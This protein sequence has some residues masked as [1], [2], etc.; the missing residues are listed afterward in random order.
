MDP[1]IPQYLYS[2]PTLRGHHSAPKL[3]Q[4]C[5]VVGAASTVA[6]TAAFLSKNVS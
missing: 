6:H 4:Q 5:F 2:E 3:K 1:L